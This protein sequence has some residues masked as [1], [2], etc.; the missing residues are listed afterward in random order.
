MENESNRVLGYTYVLIAFIVTFVY[1]RLIYQ[2]EI[3][4]EV[5][6]SLYDRNNITPSDYTVKIEMS[7]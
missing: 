6:A 3:Q 5:E 4:N 2:I 1:M 7:E